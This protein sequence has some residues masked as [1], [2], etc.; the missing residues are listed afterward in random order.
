MDPTVA[1]AAEALRAAGAE[2]KLGKSGK[3]RGVRLPAGRGVDE[4]QLQALAQLPDVTRIEAAGV[5]LRDEQLAAL[6]RLQQLTHLDLQRTAVTDAGVG[7]LAKL[8][9]LKM[10]QLSGTAVSREALKTLRQSLLGCRIVY[11]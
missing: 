8:Q 11:L 10:L 1:Q 2:I 5:P 9:S 6:A 7:E 4:S 3:V